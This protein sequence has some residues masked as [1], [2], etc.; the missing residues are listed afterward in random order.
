MRLT[1]LYTERYAVVFAP[2]SNSSDVVGGWYYL[3][4]YTRYAEQA[5]DKCNTEKRMSI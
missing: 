5:G 1:A 3:T 2:H 4:N